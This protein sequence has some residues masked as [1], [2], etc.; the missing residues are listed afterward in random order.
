MATRLEAGAY[1]HGLDA[2]T[3]DFTMLCNNALSY[4]HCGSIYYRQAEKLYTHGAQMIQQAQGALAQ[5]WKDYRQHLLHH[6]SKSSRCE[7]EDPP[8]LV[9]TDLP[10]P[11]IEKSSS[12]TEP[13]A[14]PLTSCHSSL[15]QPDEIS[16]PQEIEKTFFT[17]FFVVDM[18]VHGES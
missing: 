6:T 9:T 17:T 14:C 11:S 2:L 3:F 7:E 18:T 15:R 5:L 16:Q 12:E 4:N 1:D 10:S 13:P 8:L